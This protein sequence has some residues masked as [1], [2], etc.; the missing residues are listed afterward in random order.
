MALKSNSE[1]LIKG[2]IYLIGLPFIILFWVIGSIGKIILILSGQKYEKK[3]ETE[4]DLI[5]DASKEMKDIIKYLSLNYKEICNY[6]QINKVKKQDKLEILKWMWKHWDIQ[7]KDKTLKNE[8]PQYDIKLIKHIY[9]VEIGRM[10]AFYH[11]QEFLSNY[12]NA[13][14]KPLVW[15]SHTFLRPK[16]FLC[17]IEDIPTV[18]NF[19]IND[20][21]DEEILMPHFLVCP[22]EYFIE[23]CEYEYLCLWN[24]TE[25]IQIMPKELKDYCKKN[26]LGYHFT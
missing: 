1:Y 10:F 12:V 14:I 11:Q 16:E 3:E 6:E 8:F 7:L 13:K 22:F 18:Y 24:G 20:M 2:L 23:K 21:D 19:F 4:Q 17:T 5:I 15:V 26:N 9:S 25:F